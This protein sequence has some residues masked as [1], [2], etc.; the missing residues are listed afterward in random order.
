[1]ASAFGK[2]SNTSSIEQFIDDGGEHI[3][4]VNVWRDFVFVFSRNK[5]FV[6]F[7]RKRCLESQL[8]VGDDFSDFQGFTRNGDGRAGLQLGEKLG[9]NT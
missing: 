6:E 5:F 4:L 9:W 2:D 1:M 7:S 8:R 3:G